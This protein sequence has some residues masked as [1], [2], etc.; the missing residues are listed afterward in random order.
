VVVEEL[1]VVR[2]GEPVLDHLSLSVRAGSVSGLLGP[3]GSGKSTLLR[4]IV[5]V[6]RVAGGRSP[7]SARRLA[8][9]RVRRLG[10]SAVGRCAVAEP[11]LGNR[12]RHAEVIAVRFMR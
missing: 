2:G 12:R 3:S 6:Q 4:A 5:E 9:R 11:F 10:R 7:F 1:R 8:A